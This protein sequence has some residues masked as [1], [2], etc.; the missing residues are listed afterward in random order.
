MK[1]KVNLSNQTLEYMD[2]QPYIQG[3]DTRN[4]LNVYIEHSTIPQTEGAFNIMI[5]YALQNGRTTIK[6]A[7]TG[8]TQ[9]TIDGVVYDVF[10]FTA[11][12]VLTSV[13]GNFVATII[14]KVNTDLYKVNVLNTVLNSVEF[15]TFESALEETEATI[16]ENLENMSASILQTQLL[17]YANS[18]SLSGA[19]GT[20]T[21]EQLNVITTY[22]DPVIYYTDS[23]GVVYALQ[24]KQ[25]YQNQYEFILDVSTMVPNYVSVVKYN[26]IIFTNTKN[27][28]FTTESKNVSTKTYV[29]SAITNLQ[30]NKADITYV[31]AQ[32]LDESNARSGADTLLQ[33]Q[34]TALDNEIGYVELAST[35]GT[36]TDEQYAECL[37][38]YCIIEPVGE[39]AHYYKASES[40]AIIDF[41]KVGTDLRVFST[42][43]GISTYIYRINK[44]DKTFSL[45]QIEYYY[46]TKSQID[47]KTSDLQS[48][49]DGINAGQNLADIVADLTALG[50]LDTS[51]LQSGDKVEVLSDSN[52]DNVSTV[53]NWN[54]TTWQYIGAYGTDSYTKAQMDSALALKQNV[55]DS[56]HKLDADLVDDTNATN[57]FV[58]TSEKAQI[59]AN[60]NA[61]SGIKDGTNIDSFADVESALSDKE[62]TSNKV[63]SISSSSTD[64]EYPS[65][66][67]VYDL[68]GDVETLLAS[69]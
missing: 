15:E 53:Y 16:L 59:T 6:M 66:K 20:L 67:C 37:K 69:I 41:L 49:I 22:K 23:M 61:I 24:L 14:L 55:I 12:S 10:Y 18:I 33:N 60:Q 19:S 30:N 39:T 51:K 68:I 43:T 26:I 35:S 58:T 42:Y 34:I 65:A 2:T 29:D 54:G 11:P 13:A 50:N 25:K 47:T 38:D 45:I 52:H 64:T 48:Q 57:K 63:T 62:D 46:Y 44:S 17:I 1:V 31:D 4:K 21:D 9:E 5:A 40:S 28:I 32:I 3:T 56:S 7:N 27:W 36:L 8:A